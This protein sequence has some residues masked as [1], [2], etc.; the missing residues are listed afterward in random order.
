MPDVDGVGQVGSAAANR[1][2][3]ALR[4]EKAKNLPI[5]L[6]GGTVLEGEANE[7]QIEKR[8]LLSL[9][10]PDNRIFM[11]D[12]SRNTAEN[13]AFSKE[14]CR[15][16]GWKKPIVVTSAF[17]MPRAARFF[18]REGLDFVPYPSDYRSNMN[19]IWSPYTVVPQSAYLL[20]SCLAIKEYVGIAAASL[21]MQ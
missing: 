13:A 12:K 9:G 6:S 14:I 4:L 7:S 16:Q 2:L 5:L 15:Q 3:T 18:S 21:G 20:N 11:D 19:P 17:H 10:V 1:F 8:M